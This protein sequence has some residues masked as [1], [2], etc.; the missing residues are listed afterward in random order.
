[1]EVIVGMLLFGMVI[2]TLTAAISPLMLAYN[3][4]NDLA[5]YNQ[6]LDAIGNRIA[7]EMAKATDINGSENSVTIETDSGEIIYTALSGHLLR[8]GAPVYQP[9]FYRGKTISFTVNE[10]DA[11]NFFLILTVSSTASG[12]H[13]GSTI[14]RPYAVRPL[15]MS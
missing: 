1:M 13:T 9:E 10:D 2:M 5:E 14:S 12:R 8:N 6:L 15:L 11:P 4:A 3:R 7:S